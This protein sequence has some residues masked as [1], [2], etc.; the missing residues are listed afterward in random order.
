MLRRVSNVLKSFSDSRYRYMYWHRRIESRV[1][2]EALAQDRA[3]K[4]PSRPVA[5]PSALA[6]KLNRKGYVFVENL[7]ENAMIEEMRVYFAGHLTS[8]PYHPELGKFAAPE[9]APPGVHVAYFDPDVCLDA[10]H[11][12]KLANDPRI[13]DCVSQYF[14]CAPMIS[15]LQAWWSLPT[16]GSAKHAENFHRDFDD[17]KFC[18]LFIYL[19]DVDNQSGPHAFIA[20]SP[21][22]AK[23]EQRRRYS[24]DEV[25][26]EFP[27]KAD[28]I[29]FTGPAG[30]AFLEDTSGLHKGTP[31]ISKPRLICQV[32]YSLDPYYGGPKRPI[33]NPNDHEMQFDAYSNSAYLQF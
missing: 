20:G 3:A 26:A 11:F 24:D 6:E 22:T 29:E 25:A 33:R 27:D 32:L 18:K 17:L 2:R 10:P 4:L 15:Y 5:V 30:T 12:L 7:L 28:W 16:G 14:G 13:L 9:E 19:T 23:L 1:R 8:S 21:V 31:P